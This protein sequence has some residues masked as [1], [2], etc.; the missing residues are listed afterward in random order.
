MA[1]SGEQRRF[2]IRPFVPADQEAA[3]WLILQGLGEHFGFIDESY[4]PDLNDIAASYL[5]AGHVFLVAELDGVLVGTGALITEAEGIGRMVRVSVRR[6]QRGK[7]LGRAL[8]E[9]LVMEARARRL[10]RI[11]VETNRD[12]ADATGLYRRCGFREYDRNE[13]GVALALE[14]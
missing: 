4:N 10:R 6:E 2:L 14:L 13:V 5:A 7:G 11:L 8:V 9:R 1:S 3:R 12:W